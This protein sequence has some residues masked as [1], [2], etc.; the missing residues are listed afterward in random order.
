MGLVTAAKVETDIVVVAEALDGKE[1]IE[2]FRKHKP[3]VVIMDLRLP[4]MSGIEIMLK[5]RQEFGPVPVLVLTSYGTEEDIRRAMDAGASGYLLKDMSLDYLGEAIRVVH[6]GQKYFPPEITN[7]LAEQAAH[8]KLTTREFAVLEMIAE[9]KS[10]KEV[11]HA[12]GIVEG[13]VKIHMT[14]IL[15]KLGAMDRTQAVTMAIK[16]GLLQMK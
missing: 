16:R 14:N 15:A 13:T 12:L 4:G 2:Q 6:A 1:A 5:L 9:G 11:G 10:N 8:E 7:R 3:D